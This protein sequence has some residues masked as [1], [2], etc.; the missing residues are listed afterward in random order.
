MNWISGEFDFDIE[1]RRDITARKTIIPFSKCS[2]NLIF[3]KKSLWNTIFLVSS[4]KMLFLF[5]EKMILFFR[6]KMKDDLSQKNAWKYDIFFKCSEKVVFPKKS[7][8]NMIFLL[9]SGK[10]AFLFPKYMTF[11]LR[12]ENERWSFSKNI[13]KYNVFCMFGKNGIFFSLQIWNY[14]TVKKAKII[15]SRKIHLKMMI[16]ILEKMILA[17]DW[18]SRKSSNDSLYLYGYLFECFHILFS[19]EKKPGNLIYRIEIWLYL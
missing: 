18:H 2:E 12:T 9:S 19:S 5:P 14:P 7:H 15:F 11:F 4:G 6:R 8:W 3:P 1:H 10:M 13:W 17:L 16:L